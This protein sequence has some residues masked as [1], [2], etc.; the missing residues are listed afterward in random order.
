ME[1]QRRL[2]ALTAAKPSIPEAEVTETV[3][4][5]VGLVIAVLRGASNGNGPMGP[6]WGVGDA[7]AALTPEGVGTAADAQ[8]GYELLEPPTEWHGQLEPLR[9]HSVATKHAAVRVA[10]LGGHANWDELALAAMLH[11]VGIVI[12]ARRLPTTCRC[13][14]APSAPTSTTCTASSAR[15]TGPRPC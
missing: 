12:L 1:S 8:D 14:R 3:E 7:V 2:R 4:T 10:E 15:S 13:R 6:V 5:D 11:D 9:R